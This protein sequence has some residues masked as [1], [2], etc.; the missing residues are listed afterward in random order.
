MAVREKEHRDTVRLGYVDKS[1]VAEHVHD[2]LAKDEIDWDSV[3]IIDRAV[4]GT[5]RKMREAFAIHRTKLVMNRDDGVDRSK[6]WNA[7]L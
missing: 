1:V 2:Q 4:S 7:I 6:T 3:S 5:E